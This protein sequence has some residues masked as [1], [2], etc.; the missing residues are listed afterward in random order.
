MN[1]P[2]VW[3][4]CTAPEATTFASVSLKPSGAL[5]AKRESGRLTVTWIPLFVF[6]TPAFGT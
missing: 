4:D 1:K 6:S 5:E 3:T 2:T